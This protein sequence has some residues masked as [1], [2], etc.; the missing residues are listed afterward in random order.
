MSGQAV[1][2]CD[3]L[4]GGIAKAGTIQSKREARRKA[5]A[6]EQLWRPTKDEQISVDIVQGEV[7]ILYALSR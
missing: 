7:V 3:S 1:W 5:I 4:G 6:M 2:R